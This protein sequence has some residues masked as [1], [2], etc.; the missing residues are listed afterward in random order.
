MFY[1]WPKDRMC[2]SVMDNLKM[3]PA[4]DIPSFTASSPASFMSQHWQESH[5][6]RTRPPPKQG[7]LLH[8]RKLLVTQNLRFSYLRQWSWSPQPWPSLHQT[9]ARNKSSYLTVILSVT[10]GRG[11]EWL[12]PESPAKWIT[13][14][15]NSNV[16]RL[17]FLIRDFDLN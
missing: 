12:D 9:L 7:S 2:P 14:I 3:F 4:S 11:V 17:V 5:S 1:S 15:F 6:L 13:R 10:P 8:S 16:K